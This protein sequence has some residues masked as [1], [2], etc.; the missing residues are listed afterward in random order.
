VHYFFDRSDSGTDVV[1][2]VAITGEGEELAS[3]T[4]PTF[5]EGDVW[6]VGTL[7]WSS[8]TFTQDGSLT[9]HSLLGGP[10]VNE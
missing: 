6:K 8:L 10:D 4:S 2:S 1:G 7:D 3:V 5:E 9:T